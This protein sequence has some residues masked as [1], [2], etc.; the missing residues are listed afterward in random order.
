MNFKIYSNLLSFFNKYYQDHLQDKINIKK[1]KAFCIKYDD[2][3]SVFWMK[4]TI[5]THKVKALF[6]DMSEQL[7]NLLIH[8]LWRKLLSWLIKA[9]LIANHNLQNFDQFNQFYKWLNWSYHDVILN[10]THCEKHHQQINQKASTLPVTG[11]SAA[12]SSEPIQ[13]DSPHCELL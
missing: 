6:N 1:W 7:M 8:Q 9:H 5:L 12:R 13:Y 2:Q 11:L 3:F 4:F 10:I